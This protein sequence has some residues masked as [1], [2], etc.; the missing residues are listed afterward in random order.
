MTDSVPAPS[1]RFLA[2]AWKAISNPFFLYSRE[3]TA[4]ARW[5]TGMATAKRTEALSVGSKD[6]AQS[7]PF[8]LA[9]ALPTA[10]VAQ[11]WTE[12]CPPGPNLGP[13]R[14]PGESVR[15]RECVR[16]LPRSAKPQRTVSIEHHPRRYMRVEVSSR[17]ET[18]CRA[19]SPIQPQ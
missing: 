11:R 15:H 9:S 10:G 19:A 12:T 7:R 16:R 18:S 2:L 13:Y 3:K 8:N 5:T 1:K 6:G 4:I 17:F 14:R